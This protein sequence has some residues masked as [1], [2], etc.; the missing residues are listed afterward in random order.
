MIAQGLG[1]F[2][3]MSRKRYKID[4]WFLLKSNRKSYA[5]YRMVTLP[6]TVSYPYL[7]I[8]GVVRNFKFGL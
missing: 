1:D 5:L 2:P 4:A 7:Y 6:V 8:P 3:Q